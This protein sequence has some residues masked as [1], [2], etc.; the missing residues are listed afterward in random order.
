MND[1]VQRLKA[2]VAGRRVAV[3]HEWVD[4]YAGSEQV[5]E[6]LAQLLPDA[7]L[8]ALS[9]TPGIDL[10]VGGRDITT[11]ALDTDRWRDRRG[12]TLPAMPWAWRQLGRRDY[13]V[14]IT[15]HHAFAHTPIDSPVPAARTWPTYTALRDTSGAPT[16]TNAVVARAWPQ[17]VRC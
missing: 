2:A 1:A 15:S 7:D 5:F 16:S 12:L 17:H 6:A 11:T 9:V 4:A 3:V 14:A 8:F 13:D 10:D